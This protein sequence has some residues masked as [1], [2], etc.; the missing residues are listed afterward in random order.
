MPT[1]STILPSTRSSTSRAGGSSTWKAPTS[2]PS[3]ATRILRPTT[4]TT[5]SCTG[6][7]SP[8]RG[9]SGRPGRPTTRVGG[10]IHDQQRGDGGRI[11]GGTAG[12]TAGGDRRRAQR[13]SGEPAGRLRGD[14]AVRHDRLRRAA[15]PLPCRL[16]L[17]PEAASAACQ[18]RLAEEPHVALPDVRLRPRA[19]GGVVPQRMDR[20]RQ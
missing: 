1:T 10:P 8:I 17:R 16:P 3:P 12:G 4:N 7:T 11:P 6:L 2:T 19:H 14:D 15:P 18:P 13:D 20:Y 9:S 5:R